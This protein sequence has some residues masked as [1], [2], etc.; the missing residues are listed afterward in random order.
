MGGESG[1]AAGGRKGA[2]ECGGRGNHRLL[3]DEDARLQIK[4]YPQPRE[5]LGVL[6]NSWR[7]PPSPHTHTHTTAASV[8]PAEGVAGT[9]GLQAP[10]ECT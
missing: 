5:S 6:E 4:E 2:C 3:I 10:P 8:G 1:V 7:T 9:S